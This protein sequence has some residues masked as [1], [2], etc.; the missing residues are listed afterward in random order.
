VDDS[1]RYAVAVRRINSKSNE[2]IA[3]WEQI[4]S[5][6]EDIGKVELFETLYKEVTT[7]IVELLI[8]LW[9][10]KRKAEAMRKALLEADCTQEFCLEETYLWE[11]FERHNEIVERVQAEFSQLN[12]IP[13]SRIRTAIR[14]IILEPDKLVIPRAQFFNLII[15]LYARNTIDDEIEAL[16]SSGLLRLHEGEYFGDNAG[17]LIISKGQIENYYVDYLIKMVDD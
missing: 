1:E 15:G 11:F 5:H 3:F 2:F 14:L 9:N 13:Q 6:L 17:K 7:N 8:N 4:H 16:H 10:M 12:T